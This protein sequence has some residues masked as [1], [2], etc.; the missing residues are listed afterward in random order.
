MPE[1]GRL[2][3]KKWVAQSFGKRQIFLQIFRSVDLR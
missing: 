3:E 2:G 1:T